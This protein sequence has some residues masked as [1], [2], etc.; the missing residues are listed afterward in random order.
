MI[1]FRC[2]IDNLQRM[3]KTH[4]GGTN[5][6]NCMR[7]MKYELIGDYSYTPQ[8]ARIKEI[9]KLQSNMFCSYCTYLSFKKH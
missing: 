8:V 6:I 4:V 5:M 2:A 7:K 9:K 1:H 3:I